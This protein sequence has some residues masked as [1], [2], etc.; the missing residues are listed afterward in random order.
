MK[1]LAI[2][3]SFV[4]AFSANISVQAAPSIQSPILIEKNNV[5]PRWEKLG[6]RK[7]NYRLDRDEIWVT[8]RDGFFTKLKI[9]V[10]KGGINLHKVVVHY[11]NGSNQVVKAHQSIPAGGQSQTLDLKGNRRIITKVVFYYDTKNFSGRR[12]TVELWGRH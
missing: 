9:H 12:A 10:K 1:N 8:A 5:P 4:F 6:T 7:V 3:L 11:G 2:A